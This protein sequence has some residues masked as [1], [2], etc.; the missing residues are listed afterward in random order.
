MKRPKNNEP[1]QRQLRVGEEIRHILADIFMR[2]DIYIEGLSGISVTVTEVDVAPD[3]RN[4]TAYVSSLG[5]VMEE[6]EL[7]NILNEAAPEFN[8]LLARKLIMKFTPRLTF[9][10]DNRFD[11][12][13][14][15]E[16][17]LKKTK[18]DE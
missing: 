11:Y 3:L 2:G 5:G 6:S 8:Q 17:L 14:K 13:D 10:A 12:A 9:S 18:R 4:A 7:A 15:I 1:S 16:A